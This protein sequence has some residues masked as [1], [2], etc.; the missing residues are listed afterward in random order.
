MLVKL[1]SFPCLAIAASSFLQLRLHKR[2]GGDRERENAGKVSIAPSL[3]E[4][5][6][7]G[8]MQKEEGGG[9]VLKKRETRSQRKETEE[10]TRRNGIGDEGK[11]NLVFT[12]PRLFPPSFPLLGRSTLTRLGEERYHST[13]VLWP[14]IFAARRLRLLLLLL[15]ECLT[16]CAKKGL[17]VPSTKEGG[18]VGGEG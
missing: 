1:F 6:G 9:R 11:G 8:R 3:E 13:V 2:G 10:K 4:E 16:A 17:V 14:S 15:Q 18:F 12:F 5:E 7:C